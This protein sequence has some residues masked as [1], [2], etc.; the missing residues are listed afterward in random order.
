M[1]E[2]QVLESPSQA[3]RSIHHHNGIR[4]DNQPKNL[5][6][7]TRPQRRVTESVTRS[8]GRANS[9]S[10][11]ARWSVAHLSSGLLALSDDEPTISARVRESSPAALHGERAHRE[12]GVLSIVESRSGGRSDEID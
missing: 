12:S 10:D 5:E 9:L 8:L 11:T 6:L 4:D 1:P 3:T 2:R 7:W